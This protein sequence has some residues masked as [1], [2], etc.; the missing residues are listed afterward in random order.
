MLLVQLTKTS[1][2]PLVFL[3]Q[4][5][6]CR[7]SALQVLDHVL[8]SYQHSSEVF[9]ES[10]QAFLKVLE[11][12]KADENFPEAKDPSTAPSA[13]SP[14]ATVPSQ[15]LQHLVALIYSLMLLH[16]GFPELYTPLTDAMLGLPKPNEDEVR[17]KLAKVAWSAQAT[18]GTL[19]VPPV[20]LTTLEID[21]SLRQRSVTGCTGLVNLGNTCY[22]NR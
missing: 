4:N 16:P 19:Y 22:M 6:K 18:V 8:L 20:W 14:P 12:T 15:F 1:A 10:L 2:K 13:E 17:K 5:K 3:L 21:S 11:H 7:E 9:H